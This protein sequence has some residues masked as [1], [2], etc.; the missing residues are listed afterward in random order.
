MSA[1]AR[2]LLIGLRAA[3]SNLYAELCSDR[4]CGIFP[5]STGPTSKSELDRHTLRQLL[6]TVCPKPITFC[7]KLAD[8]AAKL[9]ETGGLSLE[10]LSPLP[11]ST[12]TTGRRP[13]SHRFRTRPKRK[14]IRLRPTTTS[15]PG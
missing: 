12:P 5:T 4:A 15:R 9:L 13:R 14:T 2:H 8:K 11:T 7:E 6:A 1:K 10:T 3:T